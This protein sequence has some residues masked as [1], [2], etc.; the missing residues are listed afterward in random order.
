MTGNFY[1]REGKH[2]YHI[3]IS[4]GIIRCASFFLFSQQSLPYA[5][6]L[7]NGFKRMNSAFIPQL[8]HE[9]VDL[10]Y[11]LPIVPSLSSISDTCLALLLMELW[12]V[13]FCK[14]WA[15][16]NK[17]ARHVEI[18]LLLIRERRFWYKQLATLRFMV[19]FISDDGKF[20]SIAFLALRVIERYMF[21]TYSWYFVC[22]L[23]NVPVV[24][25][26]IYGLHH[27]NKCQAI[28]I[29]MLILVMQFVLTAAS[30]RLLVDRALSGCVIFLLRSSESVKHPLSQRSPH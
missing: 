16:L 13:P 10:L 17:N 9:L 21:C 28:V 25:Y 30:S 19:D 15:V 23:C 4:F 29:Y 22:I 8:L 3:R 1:V 11:Y 2:T 18:L 7:K 24:L 14:H 5:S 27:R 6:N 20:Q 26:Q 12:H